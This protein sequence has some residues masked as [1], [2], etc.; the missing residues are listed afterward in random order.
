M[1]LSAAFLSTPI[2]HR[3]LHDRTTG[4]VEN[5]R[6]AVTAA[7]KAGYGI[8]IDVQASAD[9]IAMVFHDYQLDRLTHETG[10]VRARSAQMLRTIGLRDSVET[11]PTLAE[12]LALVA[13]QV[14]LLIE[15]KDQDGALGPD[16]GPLEDSVAQ[17]LQDYVG[18][19]AVMSFNPHSVAAMAKHAPGLA[20]GLTT[21]TF[22]TD[23]WSNLSLARCTHLSQIVDFDAVGATFIS[24]SARD[25][26]HPAVAALKAKGVPVLC[27]TIRSAQAEQTA[28]KIADNITFEGYTP[29]YC[30]CVSHLS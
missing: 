25:L 28:R 15:I 21:E 20:R 11:I 26:G 10:Q 16:V 14:P 27:W 19:V 1:T 22:N 3:A 13:G 23:E 18:E 24:H 12:I 8:E 29:A 7:I 30:G 9:N 2:A 17:D 5:G 4:R 6:A